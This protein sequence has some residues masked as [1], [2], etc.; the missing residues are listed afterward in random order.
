SWEL[1]P[2]PPAVVSLLA[3]GWEVTEDAVESTLLDLGARKYYEFR[4]PGNDPAQTTIHLTPRPEDAAL[5]PYEEAVYERVNGL[6]RNGLVP[7][8][9][10]TLRDDRQARQWWRTVRSAIIA[11]TSQRGLSRRRFGPGIVTVLGLV[12][13]LAGTGVGIAVFH[14]LRRGPTSDADPLGTALGAG[15]FVFLGL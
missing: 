7:L 2:E 14:N 9:A 12:A 8:S 6:A 3:N 1:G 4:Q 5:T 11:D 15:F 13:L 10:L